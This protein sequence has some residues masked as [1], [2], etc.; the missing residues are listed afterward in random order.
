LASNTVWSI[1]EDDAG[2]IYFGTERGLDQLD[3]TTGHIRHF[4]TSD[5]LAGDHVN[6]CMKDSHGYIWVATINGVSRLDPRAEPVANQAPPVYLSH[7][8][9]AGEDVPIA[10]TGAS[11]VTQGDLQA[12]RNNLL[13]QYTGIDFHDDHQ[14]RY[15]YELEGVDADWS[16]PTEQMAVNYAR[17]AP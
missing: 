9:I 6:S 14:L 8:Q 1:T 2:R 10:E 16:A 13:I 7:V 4:T 12:S 17:L 15:Q 3:L 11:V 5:G